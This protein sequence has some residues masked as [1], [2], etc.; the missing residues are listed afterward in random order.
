MTGLNREIKDFLYSELY[1]HHRVVRMAKRAERVLTALFEGYVDEPNMLPPEFKELVDERG[2]HRT[3]CD[4]LAGMTDRYAIKE[5]E[6][7]FD[8]RSTP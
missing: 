1:R 3:I 7:L 2:L 6:R 4:Y 8:P 5:Y